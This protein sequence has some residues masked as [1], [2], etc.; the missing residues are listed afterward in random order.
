M[1]SFVVFKD[2]IRMSQ[3][4]KGLIIYHSFFGRLKPFTIQSI[5][6]SFIVT[7]TLVVQ[8]SFRFVDSRRRICPVSHDIWHQKKLD[9]GNR[10]YHR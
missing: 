7:D 4:R 6:P 8:L 1:V 10:E 5:G 2:I 9:G 3:S